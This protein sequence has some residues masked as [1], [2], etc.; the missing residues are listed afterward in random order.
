MNFDLNTTWLSHDVLLIEG[1]YADPPID[2]DYVD[3]SDTV[4]TDPA[5]LFPLESALPNSSN[6]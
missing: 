3:I 1:A 2:V 4:I 5:R 6:P